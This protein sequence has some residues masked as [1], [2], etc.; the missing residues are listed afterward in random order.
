M[1]LQDALENLL[2][3]DPDAHLVVAQAL[4][5]REELADK[6]REQLRQWTERFTRHEDE[7]TKTITTLCQDRDA[8]TAQLADARRQ[9]VE[10]LRSYLKH[11]GD[12]ATLLRRADILGPRHNCSCGF[13]ALLAPSE[14][15]AKEEG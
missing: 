12:C 2:A 9:A 8:L 1:T 15:P 11:H 7:A 4:A 6:A 14:P 5:E 3:A 10:A 13:T